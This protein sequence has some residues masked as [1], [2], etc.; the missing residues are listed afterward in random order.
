[1]KPMDFK[2]FDKFSVVK[3]QDK[4]YLFT[5][6]R[7]DRKTIPEGA[8]AYDVRD[9]CGDGSFA[10][11]QH[12]VMVDH[13]GTIIGLEPIELDE[14][15]MYWCTEEDGCYTGKSVDWQT[16]VNEYKTYFMEEKGERNI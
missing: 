12:Y 3:V 16:F 15:S 4:F 11:I 14:Y 13:W 2:E 10:E 1:M 7:I 5:N 9:D 6:M 8:F